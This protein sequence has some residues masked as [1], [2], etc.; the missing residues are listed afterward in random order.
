MFLGL[1]D[2]FLDICVILP[3]PPLLLTPS[4]RAPLF[5]RDTLQSL[6]CCCFSS[7]ETITSHQGEHIVGSRLFSV[8]TWCVGVLALENHA[9]SNINLVSKYSERNIIILE[10]RIPLSSAGHHF[11]CWWARLLVCHGWN[12]SLLTKFYK[13]QETIETSQDYYT[14]KPFN[15]YSIKK[16]IY[17]ENI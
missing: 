13:L 9:G 15:D 14:H 12:V 11:T 1:S 6:L 8:F 5:S 2:T 7:G 16:S 17:D 10:A 4:L 3:R